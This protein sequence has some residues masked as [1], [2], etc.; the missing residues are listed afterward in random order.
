ML[1]VIEYIFLKFMSINV[2]PHFYLIHIFYIRLI[3]FLD[4]KGF[5]SLQNT[6]LADRQ[7]SEVKYVEKVIGS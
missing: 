5:S 7:D 6:L 3:Y 4:T 2:W 1:L